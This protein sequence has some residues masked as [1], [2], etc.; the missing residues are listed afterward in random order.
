[1]SVRGTPVALIVL[2]GLPGTGKS[3]LAN[4]LAERLGAM[5]LRIDTIEQAMRDAGQTVAGP[6]G[7]LV[8]RDIAR[9]NLRLRLPVIVDA[10]NPIAYTRRLWHDVAAGTG[11]RL[12][13]IELVCSD[14]TEHRH[15]VESR[16][17]DID[18]FRLPTWQDVLDREY[19]PWPTA[20]VV[21]TAGTSVA[22]ALAEVVRR[23]RLD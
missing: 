22:E 9:E 2:G 19:E 6:E 4:A 10:V 13:E 11:A 15:R 20:E 21:D 7:Y 17:V 1:M 12:V 8:A 5:H 3:T 14:R 18:G 23:R 16:T